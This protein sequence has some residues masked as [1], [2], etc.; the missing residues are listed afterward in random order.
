MSAANQLHWV[1]DLG[2][3]VS[4][5][6]AHHNYNCFRFVCFFLLSCRKKKI[7]LLLSLKKKNK[8]NQTTKY[9]PINKT[10]ERTAKKAPEY[11][12]DLLDGVYKVNQNEIHIEADETKP[13]ID[14]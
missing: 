13:V 14:I 11:P 9:K 7:V 1:S 8:K 12:R 10:Q 4:H 2:I 3:A 6:F 5:T